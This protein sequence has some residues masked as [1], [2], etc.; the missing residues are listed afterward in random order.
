MAKF[1]LVSSIDG[2]LRNHSSKKLDSLFDM[3]NGE[4]KKELQELKAKGDK[5]I[6]S[7]GCKHFDPKLGC[8]CRF[9]DD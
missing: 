2:L 8:R 1:H 9:Y 7:E 4:A 5:F 6:G 3:R